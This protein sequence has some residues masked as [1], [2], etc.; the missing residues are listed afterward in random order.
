MDDNTMI[1]NEVKNL[2]LVY[3]IYSER[4]DYPLGTR[5]ALYDSETG[6]GAICNDLPEAKEGLKITLRNLYEHCK[7]TGNLF[8]A[9]TARCIKDKISYPIKRIPI[10]KI[11]IEEYLAQIDEIE[12]VEIGND[13]RMAEAIYSEV[14]CQDV[15]RKRER[16]SGEN[17]FTPRSQI[18]DFKNVLKC[19]KIREDNFKK[20][21]RARIMEKLR[22]HKPLRP[23]GDRLI[24]KRTTEKDL[25]T[26]Y[27]AYSHPLNYDGN[28]KLSSAETQTYYLGGENLDLRIRKDAQSRKE[29]QADLR[30][31]RTGEIKQKKKL[32]P[33]FIGLDGNG[34]L[35]DWE[36]SQGYFLD[37]NKV[38][39]DPSKK[40]VPKKG[41]ATITQTDFYDDKQNG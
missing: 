18:F 16:Y 39:Q 22:T 17:D 35:S 30:D 14:Y 11:I 33:K 13:D 26:R 37:G 25:F 28:H 6:I 10:D 32:E 31:P 40:G 24:E 21:Q 38:F 36:I 3:I 7:A 1:E 8:Y 34:R 23:F 20:K 5:V 12:P 4:L 29:T 2:G 15:F 41:N 27:G 19:R 9:S